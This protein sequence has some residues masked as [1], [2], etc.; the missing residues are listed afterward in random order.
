MSKETRYTTSS[1]IETILKD[2]HSFAEEL[3]KRTYGQNEPWKCDAVLLAFSTDSREARNVM[4]VGRKDGH[5]ICYAVHEGDRE[6]QTVGGT[7]SI[8][9]KDESSQELNVL[10]RELSDAESKKLM[11]AI[12]KLKSDHPDDIRILDGCGV[13]A[14]FY[15][16]GYQKIHFNLMEDPSVNGNVRII[17]RCLKQIFLNHSF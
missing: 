5:L 12:K 4:A 1:S 13:E 2:L 14:E 11:I 7:I 15:W 8:P 3:L 9:F 6:I 10:C 16:N 17:R